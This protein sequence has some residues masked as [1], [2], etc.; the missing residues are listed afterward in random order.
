MDVGLSAALSHRTPVDC[1]AAP[2][3]D[4]GEAQLLVPLF[5]TNIDELRREPD[6][7]VV[8]SAMQAAQDGLR[9]HRP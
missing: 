9:K 4:A 5:V 7:L 1:V 3:R 8:A 2:Y 6:R